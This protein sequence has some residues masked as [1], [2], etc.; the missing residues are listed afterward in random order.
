VQLLLDLG[1]DVNAFGRGDVPS[2]QQWQTALHTA[3]GEG[4]LD[5][6]RLLLA[7]GADP[8]LRDNRFNGTALGWATYGGHEAV[9][10]ILAPITENADDSER[11]TQD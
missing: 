4:H 9:A 5:V 3:A 2:E 7:A 1:F 10:R 11:H 8:N 6:V